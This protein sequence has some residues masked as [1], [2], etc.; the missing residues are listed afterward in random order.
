[1]FFGI[2][3]E[4]INFAVVAY[5]VIAYGWIKYKSMC[6]PR[7]KVVDWKKVVALEHE[8]GMTHTSDSLPHC[9]MAEH[10]YPPA[11]R[12]PAPVLDGAG[13]ETLTRALGFGAIG[14]G[15]R[16]FLTAN[17]ENYNLT[18]NEVRKM[19]EPQPDIDIL[20]GDDL[21]RSAIQ[22]MREYQYPDPDF[23]RE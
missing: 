19:S 3:P 7:Q 23:D 5:F 6:P 15:T 9:W 22:A 21:L 8:H 11:D 10:K 14:P 16:K 18:P 12:V 2:D 17:Q 1:M 4:W 20:E 13:V